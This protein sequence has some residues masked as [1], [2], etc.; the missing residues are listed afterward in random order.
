M[1]NG[2]IIYTPRTTVALEFDGAHYLSLDRADFNFAA[3][4]FGVDALLTIDPAVADAECWLAAKGAADLTGLAGWH[5]YSKPGSRRLGLRLNDG[6]AAPLAVET[7]DNQIPALGTPFWARMQADRSGEVRFLVNGVD[8]GGGSISAKSG[9]LS[10]AELLKVGGYDAA[11]NRHHGT[12][13]L[14]RVDSGRLLSAAWHLREWHRLQYGGF[15]QPRDFLAYWDWYGESLA[16]RSAQAYTLTYQGG[17]DPVYLPGWPASA[18]AKT[19]IFQENFEIGHEPGYL[20]LDDHQRSTDGAAFIYVHDN[21]KKT[22]TLPFR[23]IPPEQQEAFEAA[24]AAKQ[25][26]TLYLNADEPAEPG[27]FVMMTYPLRQS[28]F[29][30]RV[31]ADLDLEEA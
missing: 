13:D 20:D 14:L 28:V 3:G 29:T 10:N 16:D 22:W 8:V 9:S 27:T 15:R 12:L 31:D 23:W 1:A 25:P 17:G 6:V 18:G 21:Q 11:T 4:D 26:L 2:K 24:W 30:D 5:F 19:Y 7:A